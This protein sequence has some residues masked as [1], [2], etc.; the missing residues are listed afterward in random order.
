MVRTASPIRATNPHMRFILGLL[1]ALL[2]AL[3]G[4]SAL[5]ALVIALAGPDRDGGIAMG[6]FFDIGPIG[7]VA[8]ASRVETLTKS[9]REVEDRLTRIFDNFN[10]LDALRKDIGGIF[11]TIRNS[12]NRIG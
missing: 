9:K 3:A 4:W 11:S 5:A 6:A 1:S 8:L 12:L 10:A 7:G 2:G